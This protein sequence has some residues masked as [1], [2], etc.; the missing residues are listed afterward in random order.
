MD[1]DDPTLALAIAHIVSAH[2]FF[3]M[4]G[5]VT[6]QE[7]AKVLPDV[8]RHPHDDM[9]RYLRKFEDYMFIEIFLKSEQDMILQEDLN[10][11]LQFISTKFLLNAVPK[12]SLK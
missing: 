8:N 10:N 2:P 1:Y 9:R 3:L 12:I 4:Y 6:L 7:I 11:R 5:G